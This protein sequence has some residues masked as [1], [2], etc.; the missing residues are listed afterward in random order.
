M[1]VH[2]PKIVLPSGPE[3]AAVSAPLYRTAM[4]DEATFISLIVAQA[5]VD[6]LMK[7]ALDAAHPGRS[8]LSVEC[9][10]RH[11]SRRGV[12]VTVNT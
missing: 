10:R 5:R 4:A 11:C 1:T 8:V 9:L 7:Y 12:I 6:Q 2:V 3:A